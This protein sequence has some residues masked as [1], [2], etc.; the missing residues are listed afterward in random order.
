MSLT[1]VKH[2]A[3][4]LPQTKMTVD[5]VI[6]RKMEKYEPVRDCFS[7]SFF[8]PVIGRMGQGKTST[9]ISLLKGA[10]K[11]VFEDILVVIPSGSLSSISPE[12]N[13]FSSLPE[14]N[15][16]DDFNEETMN[17][18]NDKITENASQKENTLLIIDDFASRFKDTKSPEFKMLKRIIITIRHKRTSILLLSQ[19]IFQM[20]KQ[21]RELATCVLFF[22]LG[23]SQNNKLIKEYLPYN[24]KQCEQIIQSFEHPHDFIVFNTK[25][26]RLFRN[27]KDELVFNEA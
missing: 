24:E 19:N 8:C 2:K 10:F 18:I 4:K 25:S 5:N 23:V 16:F 1:I 20:E 3:P 6:D 12:D 11:N 17:A 26:H 13:V 15:I 27:L 14:E 21:V 7:K 22:D 9:V